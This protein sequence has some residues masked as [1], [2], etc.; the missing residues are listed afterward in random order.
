MEAVSELTLPRKRPSH[1][2][3]RH[4]NF[5]TE[6]FKSAGNNHPEWL[7]S[8]VGGPKA[9]EVLPDEDED[10]NRGQVRKLSFFEI[11]D[12]GDD[13][14]SAAPEVEAN[15]TL[16]KEDPMQF[17]PHKETPMQ[18]DPL[19]V[20]KSSIVLRMNEAILCFQVGLILVSPF[21]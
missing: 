21:I 14:R 20:E 3:V 1:L 7:L 10:E 8:Y 6:Y 5:L 13:E 16:H 12:D 17:D 2:S 19:F 4:F 18:F 15:L 11:K 9:G